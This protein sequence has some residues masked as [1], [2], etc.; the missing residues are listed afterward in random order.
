MD[1]PRGWIYVCMVGGLVGGLLLLI[2]HEGYLSLI[3][4]G[5]FAGGLMLLTRGRAN[6]P[7]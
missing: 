3:G 7:Q 6:R 2:A 4:L 1:V 5:P